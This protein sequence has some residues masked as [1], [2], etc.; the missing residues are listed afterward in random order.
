MVMTNLPVKRHFIAIPQPNIS[1]EQIVAD[2]RARSLQPLDTDR[3]FGYVEIVRVEFAQIYGRLPV[4]LLCDLTPEF[5]R[6]F[7]GFLVD[8]AVFC[9]GVY[10]RFSGQLGVRLVDSFL[11][12]VLE[13]VTQVSQNNH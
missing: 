13:V 5:F 6:V 1:I 9:H 8:L 12:A 3:T 2:I 4:E 7:D 11:H 10:V